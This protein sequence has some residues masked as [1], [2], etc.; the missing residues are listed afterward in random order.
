MLHN[1]LAAGLRGCIGCVLLSL[2]HGIRLTLFHLQMAFLS[3]RNASHPRRTHRGIRVL[4]ASEQ[5]AGR[6]RDPPYAHW[7]D[8]AYGEGQTQR[9][10]LDA[11]ARETSELLSFDMLLVS[12]L[13]CTTGWTT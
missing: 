3:H 8:V 7:V 1:L 6:S 10:H 13:L 2:S 9:G 4:F 11:V 12:S 5:R